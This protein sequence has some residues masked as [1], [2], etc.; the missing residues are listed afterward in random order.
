MPDEIV[1]ICLIDSVKQ[2]DGYK[3]DNGVQDRVF[4][5]SKPNCNELKRL[6]SFLLQG[7]LRL[8]NFKKHK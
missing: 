6:Q 3:N 2:S 7:F 1:L 4:S 8:K 5:T